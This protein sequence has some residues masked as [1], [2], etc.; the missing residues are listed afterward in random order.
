[1]THK[2]E[3]KQMTEPKEHPI[4]FSGPMV[5]A[6]L[7]GCKTM[8]RR[9]I[10]PQPRVVHG[11]NGAYLVTNQIFRD[12]RPGLL[13]PYG[14]PGDL[15]WVR[16][17]FATR[18]LPD[19]GEQVLFKEQFRNLWSA[20]QLDQFIEERGL[21]KPDIKWKPGMFLPRELSRLTLRVTGVKVERVQ[22]ITPDDACKEGVSMEGKLFP[23]INY[24]DKIRGR[25]I[26]LWDSIN[27][28]R[29]YSWDSNPWV[30]V[31]SFE[32]ITE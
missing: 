22:E 30:W 4:L 7:E 16:E 23:L 20:L 15:L 32:R 26:T 13:C 10:Q 29:G 31:V 21:A 5:R 6:I 27:A 25:F 1:M 14:I 3:A 8:T 28:K 2:K 24:E 9:V 19:G 18:P 12:D 11:F 17:T